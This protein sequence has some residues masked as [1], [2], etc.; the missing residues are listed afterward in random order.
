MLLCIEAN[1]DDDLC[2]VEFRIPKNNVTESRCHGFL[3]FYVQA[4]L[5]LDNHWTEIGRMG[6]GAGRRNSKFFRGHTL[7][8]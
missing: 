4:H 6:C 1:N 2:S 8:T 7:R 3:S 5:A